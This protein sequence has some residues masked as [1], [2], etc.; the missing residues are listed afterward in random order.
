M[1]SWKLNI[2]QTVAQL[3]GKPTLTITDRITNE[4]GKPYYRFNDGSRVDESKVI[5]TSRIK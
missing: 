5:L 3:R 2:G 1:A 4:P